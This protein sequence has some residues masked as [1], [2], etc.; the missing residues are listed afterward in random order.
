MIQT[1]LWGH[2]KYN[3]IVTTTMIMTVWMCYRMDRNTNREKVNYVVGCP[4]CMWLDKFK[5]LAPKIM[6]CTSSCTCLC[7]GCCSCGGRMTE[8]TVLAYWPVLFLCDSGHRDHRRYWAWDLLFLEELIY[9][10]SKCLLTSIRLTISSSDCQLECR[11][12]SLTMCW[13]VRSL[14]RAK[15]WC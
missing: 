12:R 4:V 3:Y 10:S 6:L 14:G 13:S 9:V 1:N 2:R 5:C 15:V 7:W 11:G 8:S